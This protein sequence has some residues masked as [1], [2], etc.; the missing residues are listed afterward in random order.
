MNSQIYYGSFIVIFGVVLAVSSF[1]G[2]ALSLFY[3]VLIFVIGIFILLN[4]KEDKIEEI[5]DDKK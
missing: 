5:M 1:F 3:G 4:K 2:R